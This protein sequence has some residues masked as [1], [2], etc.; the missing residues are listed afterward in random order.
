MACDASDMLDNGSHG[1][2]GFLADLPRPSSRVIDLSEE[3]VTDPRE[4]DVPEGEEDA[5]NGYADPLPDP[6]DVDGPQ[7]SPPPPTRDGTPW[8][9]RQPPTQ[10]M[11]LEALDAI[12][13]LLFVPPATGKR[14]R[15]IPTKI[16]G[17]ERKQLEEM[18]AFLSLYMNKESKTRGEWTAS[19]I[20][21]AVSRGKGKGSRDGQPA[22][23][24]SA[25]ASQSLWKVDQ[26]EA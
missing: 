15:T 12:Q 3:L 8:E 23:L 6:D 5:S 20:Q 24:A 26:I 22:E 18:S 25:H 19:S 2:H 17:W 13:L 1:H 11:A 14:K 16:N 10:V 4:I 21:A 7:N 9:T